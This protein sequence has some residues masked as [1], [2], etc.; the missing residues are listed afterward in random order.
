MNKKVI[1]IGASGHGKVIADIIIKSGD[2]VVGF[3]DDNPNLEESFIG[4]PV[5]GKVSDAINYKENKFVVAIGNADVREKI[6]NELDVNWY[7]AIHPTAV[8]SSIGVEIGEGT[9]VMANAVINS[10]AKIGNHCIINTGAIVE[11]DNFIEDFVHVSVG[12]KLAGIVTVGRKSW[13]GIGSQVIQCK[14]ICSEVMIGAGATV[15]S[16]IQ[17]KGTY[18]G[19]PAKRK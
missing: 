10:D 1:I 17:E 2:E 16:D 13:I 5:L 7:T 15:I 11:H 8:I 19:V 9:V 12:A 18:V 6:V 14:K 3:L 4:F